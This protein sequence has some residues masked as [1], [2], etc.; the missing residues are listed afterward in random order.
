MTSEVLPYAI[1]LGAVIVA[2]IT[3]YIMRSGKDDD[4]KQPPTKAP[5]I[6]EVLPLQGGRTITQI[7]A[8]QSQKQLR[9]LD[10][11]REILSYG[12]RR[13]YEAQAEGKLTESERERLAQSYKQRMLDIKSKINKNESVVALHQLESMQEDL[14]K[15]FNDRFDEINQK[16]GGLRT[17]LNIQPKPVKPKPVAVPVEEEAKEKAAKTTTKKRPKKPEKSKKT[18]AEERIEQIKSE[19]EK[20]LER[21]GQMETEA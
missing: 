20:V 17:N 14:I 15:L 16:I 9:L 8:Q 5:E 10:V 6:I 21:L 7:D 1:A 19:V 12:I 13:L 3:I 11:E 4:T 18:E 2:A